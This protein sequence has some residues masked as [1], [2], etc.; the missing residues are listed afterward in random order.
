MINKKTRFAKRPERCR[1]KVRVGFGPGFLLFMLF[2][3]HSDYQKRKL[4]TVRLKYAEYRWRL[5]WIYV[6]TIT[7]FRYIH[8]FIFVGSRFGPIAGFIVRVKF[9]RFSSDCSQQ[10]DR[11]STNTE[12]GVC[13]RSETLVSKEYHGRI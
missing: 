3:E 5:V 10:R 13:Q 4:R 1:L 7:Y 2:R 6:R 11:E 8:V 12:Y 9:Y